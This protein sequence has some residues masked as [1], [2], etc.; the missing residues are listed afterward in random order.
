MQNLRGI[1]M[2]ANLL[3]LLSSVSFLYIAAF[4]PLLNIIYS[5]IDGILLGLILRNGSSV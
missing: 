2:P 3:F 4:S 1:N 5:K